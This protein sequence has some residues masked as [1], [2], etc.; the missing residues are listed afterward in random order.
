MYWVEFQPARASCTV[1][2]QTIW[3]NTGRTNELEMYCLATKFWL[4]QVPDLDED[5]LSKY[6]ARKNKDN[7]RSVFSVVEPSIKTAGVEIWKVNRVYNY[8][9]LKLLV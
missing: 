4:F 2:K 8:Q 7:Y 5:I 9:V 6:D 3:G 1:Q